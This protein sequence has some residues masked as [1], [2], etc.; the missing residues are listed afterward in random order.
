ML[1]KTRAGS[2][3]KKIIIKI[4]IEVSEEEKH[5]V[6][7]GCQFKGDFSSDKLQEIVMHAREK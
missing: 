4:I 3:E 7:V 5:Y 2:D 6:S 1:D